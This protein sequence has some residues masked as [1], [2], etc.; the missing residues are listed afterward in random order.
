MHASIILIV[1][2][3]MMSVLY[4]IEINMNFNCVKFRQQNHLIHW[5]FVYICS[6]GNHWQLWQSQCQFAQ[7]LLSE[8]VCNWAEHCYWLLFCCTHVSIYISCIV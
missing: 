8:A 3:Y 2:F 6:H 4:S 5:C 7:P 1:L